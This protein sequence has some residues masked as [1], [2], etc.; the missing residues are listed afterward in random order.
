MIRNSFCFLE[1]IGARTEERLWNQSITCW[2]DFIDAKKIRGISEKR[3]FYYTNRLNEAKRAVMNNDSRHFLSFPSTEMWR[4]YDWFCDEAVYLDI[5]TGFN[6]ENMTHIS[7][8][9]LY[10][11]EQTKT[12]VSGINLH[13]SALRKELEKYK[14]I[15][16]FNGASFDLPVIK[17]HFC[18]TPQVPHL[19]LRFACGHIGLTGGLKEIERRLGIKRENQAAD[20][21]RNDAA[22][23]W[24][25][26]HS[27][28]NDAYL[29]RLV[30]YNEEDAVNLKQIAKEVV[31]ALS[32]EMRS[33]MYLHKKQESQ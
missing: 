13:R 3:R 11:G 29:A 24:K 6:A 32:H 26:W 21:D 7:I 22:F 30:E 10:D 33:K 27:T 12:F 15:V 28:R 2:N 18:F 16:T 8:I 1:G 9:T 31:D 20:K 25:M 19:D 17:K 14:L 4:L 5:E 23:L